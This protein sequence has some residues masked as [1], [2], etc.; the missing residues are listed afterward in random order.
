MKRWAL[1]LAVLLI[2]ATSLPAAATAVGITA[3]VQPSQVLT[4]ACPDGEQFDWGVAYFYRKEGGGGGGG[5][6]NGPKAQVVRFTATTDGL[7]GTV[8]VPKGMYFV[9]GSIYCA[10][11]VQIQQNTGSAPAYL[12]FYCPAET[13]TITSVSS[14]RGDLDGNFSTTDDQSDMDWGVQTSPGYPLIVGP[15]DPGLYVRAAFTCSA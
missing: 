9:T 10:N 12:Y 3:N 7:G 1:P 13:Q 15:V 6:G 2:L 5:I 11:T 14:A 8:T 4:V